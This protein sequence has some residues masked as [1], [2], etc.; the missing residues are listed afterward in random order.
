MQKYLGFLFLYLLHT[1]CMA[2]ENNDDNSLPQSTFYRK[3]DNYKTIPAS[4]VLKAL[5]SFQLTFFR[6]KKREFR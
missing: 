2:S 1:V 4:D 5:P 6:T 3:P